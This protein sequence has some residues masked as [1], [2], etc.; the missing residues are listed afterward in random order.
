MAYPL[1]SLWTDDGQ[2]RSRDL[3]TKALVPVCRLSGRN[4]GSAR[5][6]YLRE[7]RFFRDSHVPIVVVLGTRVAEQRSV[8]SDRLRHVVPP[9]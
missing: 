5:I 4:L 1:A 2:S 8:G 9:V 7:H 6:G 3:S